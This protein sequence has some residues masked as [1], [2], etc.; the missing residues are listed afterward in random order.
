MTASLSSLQGRV[1]FLLA[2]PASPVQVWDD[3][4][5]AEAVRQALDAY[6]LAGNG[7]VLLEGLDGAA[8]TTLPEMHESL[9]VWGASGYAALARSIRRAESF[10]LG[11]E[12]M[13]LQAW[14]SLRLR[15]FQ[16]ALEAVR[17]SDL[18][19]GH[20]MPWGSWE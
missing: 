2:D 7:P 14:G 6:H 16:A 12:P 8:V 19:R 15:S 11:S 9:I 13:A 20:N 18:H 17:L 1:R 3:A 4:T 10:Q 5:L